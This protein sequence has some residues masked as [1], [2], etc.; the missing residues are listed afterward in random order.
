MG[1]L[2]PGVNAGDPDAPWNQN[3]PEP[4]GFC[5]HCDGGFRDYETKHPVVNDFRRIKHDIC[6]HCDEVMSAMMVDETVAAIEFRAGSDGHQEGE[7]ANHVDIVEKYQHNG[8][9]YL[10]LKGDK[11]YCHSIVSDAG[12]VEIVDSPVPNHVILVIP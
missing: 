6:P 5:P 12:H 4:T 2:P 10:T 8:H 1:N 11:D 9:T 3:Y 7:W